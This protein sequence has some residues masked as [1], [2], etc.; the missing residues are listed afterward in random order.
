MKNY[1][2]LPYWKKCCLFKRAECHD[3]EDVYKRIE[4]ISQHSV[5]SLLTR[6]L[7]S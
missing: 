3:C 1:V 5:T 4:F 2:L 6:V 7:V